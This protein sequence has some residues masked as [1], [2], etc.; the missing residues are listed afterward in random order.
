MSTPPGISLNLLR[1]SSSWPASSNTSHRKGMSEENRRS[2]LVFLDADK[3]ASRRPCQAT[4]AP[5]TRSA[6]RSA[7]ELLPV[8]SCP[9][10]L[11]T[12]AY[13]P[14]HLNASAAMLNLT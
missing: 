8:V 9:L 14:A 1:S 5:A 12:L 6:S 3:P 7:S 11:L 10:S 2:F 4:H 13:S